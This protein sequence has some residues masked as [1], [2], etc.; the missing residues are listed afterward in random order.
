[1]SLLVTVGR[2]GCP[3]VAEVTRRAAAALGVPAVATCGDGLRGVL[4]GAV[5]P[6]VV[7]PVAL[8]GALP[9]GRPLGPHPLLAAAQASRLIAAG[10]RPGRAVVMVA[11]GSHR[12]EDQERLVRA[13]A[14]LAHT[15]TGPVRLAAQTGPV[16]R[17]EELLGRGTAV[18]PYL[19]APGPDADEVRA[20]ASAAGAPVVADVLG[21]H[22][23]LVELVVRRYRARQHPVAA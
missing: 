21:A 6:P 10:A 3:V 4:A 23:F 12:P 11:P 18:S 20:T 15:W 1:M 14:L 13:A 7:V 9:H 2:P 16:P 19:L 17:P 8:D 5:R 22:R